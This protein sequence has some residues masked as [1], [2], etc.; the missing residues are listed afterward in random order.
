MISLFFIFFL[1]GIMFKVIGWIFISFGK[2]IGLLLGFIIYFLIG[3]LAIGFLGIALF[4]I[5]VIFISGV[6][7]IIKA[8]I[9]V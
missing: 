8:L 3:C 9:A 1:L 7:A 6:I 5:P 4:I 2:V